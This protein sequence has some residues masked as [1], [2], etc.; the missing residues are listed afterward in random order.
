MSYQQVCLKELRISY[1]QGGLDSDD[2]IRDDNVLTSVWLRFLII[3]DDNKVY[4]YDHP[5]PTNS[6]EIT[7]SLWEISGTSNSASNNLTT[8]LTG[9][10]ISDFLNGILMWFIIFHC[11]GFVVIEACNSKKIT[12][13][14]RFIPEGFIWV[15]KKNSCLPRR[16]L[17]LFKV[18]ES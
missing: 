4:V 18:R 3:R 10:V 11:F 9:K 15:P 13:R 12:H 14:G 7:G 1:Y 5:L 2:V 8:S 17:H 16:W 6:K